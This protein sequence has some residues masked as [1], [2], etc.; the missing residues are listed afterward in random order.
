LKK[1]AANFTAVP[2]YRQNLALS[3][4][5]LG[6]LLAD[7]GKRPEAEEQYR[8]ALAHY[9]RLAADF[10]TMPEYRQELAS[11]HYGL[12]NLLAGLGKRPEAE[13]QYRRALALR[14]KLAD[15]SPAVPQYRRDLALS[16]NGLGALLFG[17][18]KRQEAEQRFREALA[19]QEK[20]AAD[21]SDV[22]EYQIYLGGAYNNFGKLI[23]VGGQPGK[24]LEW[25]VK[26]VRILTAVYDQDRQLVVAKQ[27]LR[28]SHVGRAMAYDALHQYAEAVQ[29]WDRAVELSPPQEQPSLRARRAASRVQ[30]GQVAEAV[31][32]AAELTKSSSWKAG[33]WYD[34]AC[35][36]AVASGKS[37]GKTQEYAERAMQLLHQA[38]KA[39]YKDAAHMSKDTDLDSLRGRE[40]FKKLMLELEQKSAAAEAKQP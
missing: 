35:I 15:D 3:H 23:R 5:N 36:Y 28:N 1:L 10:P 12:G 24:S 26:A 29:D 6:H 16:H 18:G 21:F 19:L 39:G 25:Y 4:H 11:S 2:Q 30:A 37:G 13:E 22:P 9:E 17:L 38:V 32:E 14:K 20:L 7:L 33:Q 8:Q 34:F 31:A 27:F 40:D